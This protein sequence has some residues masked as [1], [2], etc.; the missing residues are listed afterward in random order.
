MKNFLHK[1]Q[2]PIS[3]ILTI[4]GVVG[5]SIIW[6]YGLVS[7]V[8]ADLADVSERTAILETS[9]LNT[10]KNVGEIKDDIKD[11]RNALKIK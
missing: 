2:I 1:G 7:P 9:I 6:I 8:K 3:I 11:I 5:G 4:G 10:D